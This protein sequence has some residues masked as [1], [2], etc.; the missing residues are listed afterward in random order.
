M[1]MNIIKK[2]DSFLKKSTNDSMEIARNCH[3]K[4]TVY[5]NKVELERQNYI[6]SIEKERDYELRLLLCTMTTN[7][8]SVSKE[9]Q[10]EFIKGEYNVSK[11]PAQ[12]LAQSL[13]DRCPKCDRKESTCACTS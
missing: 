10:G 7:I 6:K 5:D 11:T 12:S 2:L 9:A 8:E 3:R 13:A 1:S 4:L